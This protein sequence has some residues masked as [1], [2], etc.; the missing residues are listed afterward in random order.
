M[1][2]L[3]GICGGW[4]LVLLVKVWFTVLNPPDKIV[5]ALFVLITF[6]LSFSGKIDWNE[7]DINE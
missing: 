2:T 6:Y 7:E 1:K 3:H 5:F 4:C